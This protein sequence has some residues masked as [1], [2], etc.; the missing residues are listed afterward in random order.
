VDTKKR[1]NLNRSIEIEE[2]LR[3]W[4]VMGAETLQGSQKVFGKSCG[5]G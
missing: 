2:R 5:E 1:E 3:N 4:K